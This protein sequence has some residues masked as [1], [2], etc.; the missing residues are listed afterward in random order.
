MSR[1]VDDVERELAL[2]AERAA[3]ERAKFARALETRARAAA[4]PLESRRDALAALADDVDRSLAEL[5]AAVAADAAAPPVS[6]ADARRMREDADRARRDR[7]TIARELDAAIAG[8]RET[9]DALPEVA[10][11]FERTFASAGASD[12]NGG[13]DEKSEQVSVAA[14]AEP[15]SAVGLEDIHRRAAE[16]EPDRDPDEVGGRRRRGRR[17]LGIRALDVG[18]GG[19]D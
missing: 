3:N 9:F 16:V 8:A 14:P 7:D 1:R 13:G 11:T 10:E 6:A 5:V 17:L 18:G 4:A 2:L 19:G 15:A 12:G